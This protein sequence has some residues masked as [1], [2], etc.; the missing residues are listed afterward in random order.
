[1]QKIGNVIGNAK[2]VVCVALRLVLL[3]I[4][5]DTECTH[6]DDDSITRRI[7]K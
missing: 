2:G 5:M 1:M 4:A 3:V 6:D 7:N